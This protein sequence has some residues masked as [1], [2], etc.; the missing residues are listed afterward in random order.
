MKV[1]FRLE[2]PPLILKIEINAE[3]INQKWA[4]I[5][6][7]LEYFLLR[8][9]VRVCITDEELYQLLLSCLLIRFL[10]YVCVAICKSRLTGLHCNQGTISSWEYCAG[11][12]CIFSNLAIELAH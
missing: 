1:D 8:I 5:F 6:G 12:A 11:E 4:A 10:E 2:F 7:Y 3:G 9:V